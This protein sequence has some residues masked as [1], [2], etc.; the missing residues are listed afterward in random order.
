MP[1]K[2]VSASCNRPSP[3]SRSTWSAS[4]AVT[5]PRARCSRV[6]SSTSTTFTFGTSSAPPTT[7]TIIA[8][9]LVVP[10][11]FIPIKRGSDVPGE[12]AEVGVALLEEGVA[13][14]GRL[15]GHVGQPRRLPREELLADQPVVD[16]VERVLEHPLRG[17][18]LGVD[19]R[20]PTQRLGLQLGV[21]HHLVHRA[22]PVR[23]L[24]G[25]LLAE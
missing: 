7:S 20:G 24:G 6:R 1:T 9:L 3:A 22:H 2:P 17:R 21:R 16:E 25:V 15:L 8:V 5:S 14:L 10:A 23:V 18:A 13:A 19:D 12:A 11:C 4:S